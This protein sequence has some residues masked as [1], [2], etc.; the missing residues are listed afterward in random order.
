MRGNED[1]MAVARARANQHIESIAEAAAATVRES[2]A[3]EV[4]THIAHAERLVE[5]ADEDARKWRAQFNRQAKLNVSSSSV[6]VDILQRRAKVVEVVERGNPSMMRAMID[7]L[8]DVEMEFRME[9]G[10]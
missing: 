10:W 2:I 6:F 3:A 9:T 7:L 8:R 4:Y 1:P 5:R